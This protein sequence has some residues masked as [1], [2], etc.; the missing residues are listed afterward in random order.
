MRA[1]VLCSKS[2]CFFT[3]LKWFAPKYLILCSIVVQVLTINYSVVRK[4]KNVTF[5]LLFS[6]C[7]TWASSLFSH[8]LICS[9]NKKGR[10]LPFRIRYIFGLLIIKPQVLFIT[11]L[12]VK[13]Y[14]TENSN[15]YT[16]VRGNDQVLW[17]AIAFRVLSGWDPQ[18]MHFPTLHRPMH[19]RMTLS[20]ACI[21][22]DCIGW[23]LVIRALSMVMRTF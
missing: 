18:S 20:V 13:I 21:F 9:M 5:I 10:Y 14:F 7:K 1:Y 15:N 3:P 17:L 8:L 6:P 12:R 16:S 11:E 2:Q 19:V 4:D 22:R 23:T